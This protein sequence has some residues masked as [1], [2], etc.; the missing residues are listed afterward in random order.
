MNY[1]IVILTT[2]ILFWIIGVSSLVLDSF[3]QYKKHQRELVKK[4][5]TPSYS[6][7]DFDDD[8]IENEKNFLSEDINSLSEYWTGSSE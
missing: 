3:L 2:I 7:N 8:F 6:N 4:V 5:K 1:G